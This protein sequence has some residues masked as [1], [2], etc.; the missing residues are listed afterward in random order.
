MMRAGSAAPVHNRAKPAAARE[1][2]NTRLLVLLATERTTGDVIR[3]LSKLEGRD[4]HLSRDAVITA[5]RLLELEGRLT[6]RRVGSE[7]AWK[8]AS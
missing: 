1:A 4:R 3:E 8:A 6:S 2:R 7:K 5:L